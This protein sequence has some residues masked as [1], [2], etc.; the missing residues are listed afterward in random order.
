MVR[1]ERV[2]GSRRPGALVVFSTLLIV[3]LY[4]ASLFLSAFEYPCLFSGSPRIIKGW[5]AFLCFPAGVFHEY[6]QPLL[7]KDWERLAGRLTRE[8]LVD[9]AWHFR[10]WLP[11]PLLWSSLI[12]MMKGYRHVPWMM[13]VLALVLGLSVW[14]TEFSKFTPLV[15]YYLWLTSMAVLSAVS[16]LGLSRTTC[17]WSRRS[18]RLSKRSSVL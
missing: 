8:L 16:V 14:L 10:G 1:R 5:E 2:A 12:C 4:T 9:F 11:N 17:N 13:A 3:G 15:G 6:F 18:C 7:D